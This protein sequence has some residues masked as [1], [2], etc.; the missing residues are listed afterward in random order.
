V[1]SEASILHVDMDAFFVSVELLRHPELRGRPVVVGGAGPRGVVAAA[2]Y[3]ARAHGVHSAM[4]GARARRLCPHAVFLPGDHAH[5]AEVSGRVMAIFRSFT[6]LVEPLSLD[7]AFLDVAGARRLLGDPVDI[8]RAL[9]R[10]V[11]DEEGLTC[12]VGA[13][14]VK[15][16]AKLATEAAKPA[17]SPTGPIERAGVVEVVPGRELEFLHPLPVQALWGVGPATLA[18]LQRLGVTTVGDLAALPLEAL[19]GALGRASGQHLHELAHGRDPRGVVPDQQPKSISHEET[20][21]H[22]RFDRASLGVEVVRLADAVGSRLRAAG[23]H[24]RTITVKVRFGDFST[25][26]RSATLPTATDSGHRIAQ[27]SQDLLD[28]VDVAPGVRLLGIGVSHLGDPGAE[29]LSFDDLAAPQGDGEGWTAAESALDAV[30]AR[31]G[32]EAIGPASLTGPKGLRIAR[33]GQQQ[34]GPDAE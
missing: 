18:R 3:E 25:I 11:L 19:V 23:T 33:R 2:S 16:L 1:R 29:Q 6:P 10:R 27:V 28:A 13:A 24:G 12:S 30:R 7:E 26:T 17:A 15:F 21:A 31:F 22:D 34:W 8:A 20:F 9:R 32:A 4:P 5:Y 14:R